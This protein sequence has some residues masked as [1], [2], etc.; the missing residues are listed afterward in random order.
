MKTGIGVMFHA[1]DNVELYTMKYEGTEIVFDTVP[2]F[3]GSLERRI[4]YRTNKSLLD[5]LTKDSGGVW[6]LGSEGAD[7]RTFH[8]GVEPVRLP[9][10]TI[11]NGIKIDTAFSLG[12]EGKGNHDVEGKIIEDGEKSLYKIEPVIDGNKTLEN[13]DDGNL[14]VHGQKRKVVYNTDYKETGSYIDFKLFGDSAHTGKVLIEDRTSTSAVLHDTSQFDFKSIGIFFI[15]KFQNLAVRIGRISL[16]SYKLALSEA[17]NGKLGVIQYLPKKKDG[18]FVTPPQGANVNIE[19]DPQYLFPAEKRN[20]KYLKVR[21]SNPKITITENGGSKL[22]PDVENRF[23]AVDADKSTMHID[24]RNWE[25]LDEHFYKPGTMR[26]VKVSNEEIGVDSV[27]FILKGSRNEGEYLKETLRLTAVS[28]N[29]SEHENQT[30]GFDQVDFSDLDYISMN[31]F[32]GETQVYVEIKPFENG[33]FWA[34]SSDFSLLSIDGESEKQL[35]S[36]KELIKLNIMKETPYNSSAFLEIRS[37]SS[38]G[39]LLKKLNVMVYK[40][41]NV[42]KIYLI[43]SLI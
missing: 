33:N 32:F 10:A 3:D 17:Y 38:S 35:S 36:Q 1:S 5:T 14:F 16:G 25:K 30:N 29:F 13:V 43:G 21:W 2:F 12:I 42:Q 41:K 37:G 9:I 4:I 23:G 22:F 11:H 6:L 34:K 18:K 24:V 40:Q 39:K 27:E 31:G 7:T 20:N 26:S 15:E 19:N 8:I 28:V